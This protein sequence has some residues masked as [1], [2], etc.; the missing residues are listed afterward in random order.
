MHCDL[1]ETDRLKIK[2][3]QSSV[4]PPQRGRLQHTHLHAA[5]AHQLDPISRSVQSLN[6]VRCLVWFR[7]GKNLALEVEA[8]LS[9]DDLTGGSYSLVVKYEGVPLITKNGDLKEL[10]LV[11]FPIKAGAFNPFRAALNGLH[12]LI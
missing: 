4:W 12:H 8:E 7:A 5:S 1:Q 3:V 10:G 6:R 11:S 2:K 9:G